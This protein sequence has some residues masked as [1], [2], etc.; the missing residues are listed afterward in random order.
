MDRQHILDEIKRTAKENGGVPLG[1]RRFENETAIRQPD[2]FGKYW[3]RWSAALQEAGFS[4]NEFRGE[5][6]TD[7]EMVLKLALLTRELGH[8]PGKGDIRI[9]KREDA[10]FP[11]DKV[12][13]GRYG[14][15]VRQ[16]ELVRDYC[17]RH[18][19]FTDVLEVCGPGKSIQP[20]EEK[21]PELVLGFVY[22]MKHGRHYKIGKTNATGRREYELAIQLPEKL[23]TI[24][25]IKTDDPD[26]IEAYWHKRFAA[27]RGNGE[28]FSLDAADIQAF[29]RRKFM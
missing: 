6:L 17:N 15:G 18:D 7:E 22:L 20:R 8:F 28:W 5:G 9:K 19:G 12:F 2:W 29:K 16:K 24:H 26:G 23:T 13:Y 25:V 1:S 14:S 27:K 11:N 10:S 21:V 4:P 3:P